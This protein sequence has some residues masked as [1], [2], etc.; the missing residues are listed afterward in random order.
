VCVKASA[1]GVRD[2]TRARD[3]YCVRGAEVRVVVFAHL[4]TE[5]TCLHSPFS[6]QA[7]LH[8]SPH[9]TNGPTNGSSAPSTLSPSP[10]DQS[11]SSSSLLLIRLTQFAQYPHSCLLNTHDYQ[12]ISPSSQDADYR[13]LPHSPERRHLRS[14]HRTYHPLYP[15]HSSLSLASSPSAV[16]SRPPTAAAPPS[17]PS[18]TTAAHPAPF[19]Q[20]LTAP[21]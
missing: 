3:A 17:S 9:L 10:K 15:H 4:L 18:R 6:R 21:T 13:P 11:R 19:P 16:P 20:A 8:T 2:K 1:S 7:R 14:T 12:T 5:R